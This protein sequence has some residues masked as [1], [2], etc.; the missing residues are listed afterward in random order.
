MRRFAPTAS[1]APVSEL[2]LRRW[3][4]DL[5]LLVRSS[6]VD[7]VLKMLTPSSLFIYTL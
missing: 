4:G 3:T 5:R 6:R 1:S 7:A 2:Y